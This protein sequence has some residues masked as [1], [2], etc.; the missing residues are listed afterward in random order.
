VLRPPIETTAFT[1][2]WPD[3]ERPTCDFGEHPTFLKRYENWR[4]KCSSRLAG[5]ATRLLNLSHNVVRYRTV[6]RTAK[7]DRR[8]SK[9]H[10]GSSWAPQIE[11]RVESTYGYDCDSRLGGRWGFVGHDRIPYLPK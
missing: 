1:G 5:G 3:F 7:S 4:D 2:S 6:F 9:F 11:A 10:E 8:I